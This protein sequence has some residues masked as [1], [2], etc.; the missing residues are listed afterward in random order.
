[1]KKYYLILFIC[2]DLFSVACSKSSNPVD[3]NAGLVNNPDEEVADDNLLININKTYQVIDG[4]GA[5]DCWCGNYIGRDWSE[6]ERSD[7]ADLLFSKE[8]NGGQPKGIGLSMWRSNL[9][10]GTANLGDA[11]NVPDK[12]R[13]AE[14]YLKEDGTYDWSQAAGQRYFLKAAKDRGCNKFVLFSLSA[15]VWYTKNGKAYSN[16]GATTNLKDGYYGK[17]ADYMAK[18]ARHYEDMGIPIT[19]ISPVNEPQYVWSSNKQEGCGWTNSQIATL[20]GALDKSLTNEALDTKISLSEAG[21]YSFLYEKKSNDH[22]HSDQI[23]TFFNSSSENY[24]G[25]LSHIGDMIGGHSYWTDSNMSQLKSVRMKLGAAAAAQG[26]KTYQT[27]WSMLGG[28]YNGS[29]FK[30]YD[31]SSYM[32]IAMYMSQVIH[33][34]LAYANNSAWFFWTAMDLE[35]YGQKDR[36]LLISLIPS[37]GVYGDI[38]NSGTHEARK[39][40]WVLG[41]YSL[42]IRPGYKRVDIS[43]G[44]DN[45][46]F[47]TAYIAPDGKT[48]VAVMTNFKT[49]T[50]TFVPKIDGFEATSG[51]RYV[52]SESTNLVQSDIAVNKWEVPANSVTT[53]VLKR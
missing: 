43:E 51:K 5:S 37:D 13:R 9:G 33:S 36:F 3:P 29:H 39:T 53:F 1:M 7:I 11:S 49:T 50:Q 32:D 19:L 28:G 15:P 48:L 45:D 10:A 8:M 16:L 21:S 18:V 2:I 40:L 14:C 20:C 35:R 27:E 30:G 38:S 6:S 42:F 25:D 31:N 47:G 26:L 44:T 24:L 23:N 12:S 41:N 46:C 4:F 52:T 17:F 22:N 34:D